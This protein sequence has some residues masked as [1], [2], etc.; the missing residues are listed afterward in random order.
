MSVS[1]DTVVH[2][3]G[4]NTGIP[5]P[6]EVLTAL[7]AGRRPPVLVQVA[8]YRY[9]STVGAM[10]GLS[11]ISLS[12]AHREA[13][14]L[15]AGDAVTVTLTLDEGPR[16]TPVPAELAEAL[17]QHGLTAAFAALSPSRRKE[18]ARQVGEAKT[19]ATRQRRIEAIVTALTP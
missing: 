2:G 8:G 10:A 12:K 4:T 5:V 1:Y 15:A 9:R 18:A 13:S 17:Y 16:D 19:D 3:I 11:L 6:D 7:G 14:G